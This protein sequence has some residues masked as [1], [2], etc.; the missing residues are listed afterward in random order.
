M[1]RTIAQLQQE[2]QSGESVIQEGIRYI[3][4][5]CV[6]VAYLP[7]ELQICEAYQI[8]DKGETRK[9]NLSGV[10]EKLKPGERAIQAAMRGI[11]EELDLALESDRFLSLGTELCQKISKGYNL[12]TVY[13]LHKFSLELTKEEFDRLYPIYIS[14]E[15]DKT[16][17]FKWIPITPLK[18]TPA[19]LTQSQTSALSDRPSSQS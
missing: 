5:A 9:R 10:S 7:A 17:V 13:T 14:Q 2:I 11:Q 18:I 3:Q 19:S 4:V 1:Q 16:S 6:R 8:L 15:A 12:P